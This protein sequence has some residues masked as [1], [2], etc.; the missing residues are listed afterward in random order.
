MLTLGS[1]FPNL[2]VSYI[3]YALGKSDNIDRYG[4]AC[5][6]VSSEFIELQ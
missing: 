3:I 1:I 4:G 5:G 6:D 2:E